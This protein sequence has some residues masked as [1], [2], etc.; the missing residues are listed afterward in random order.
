[1]PDIDLKLLYRFGFICHRKGEEPL[2]DEVWQAISKDWLRHPYGNFVVWLHP[3]TTLSVCG[4]NDRRA[5]VIGDAIGVGAREGRPLAQGAAAVSNGELPDVLYDYTGRF[6]LFILEGDDAL[7]FNDPIGSRSVF[8]TVTDPVAVAS[9]AAL[10][11][12]AQSR[13][14][15]EDMAAFVVSEPFRKRKPAYLP[16]DDTIHQDTY[17]LIANN[18]F[19]VGQRRSIRYWPSLR[20]VKY[21]FDELLA[22]FDNYFRSLSGFLQ[23]KNTIV[24]ITGGIDSRT[25]IAGLRYY[26]SVPQGVTW[27]RYVFNEPERAVIELVRN[28]TKMSHR[29]ID[30]NEYS[31]NKV[32]VSAQE[33]AGGFRRRSLVVA[34]M[35]DAYSAV[36][37]PVYVRGYGGEILRAPKYRIRNTMNSM[38]IDDM[39]KAY[40]MGTRKQHLGDKTYLRAI[41]ACYE[42][43]ASRVT[44]ADCE[45]LDFNPNDIFYWENRI[46]TWGTHMMNEMDPAMYSM[47]GLNSRRLFEMAF[48]LP[49]EIRFP[50]GHPKELLRRVIGHYD[51]ELARVPHI[52]GNWGKQSKQNGKT[53]SA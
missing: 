34:A 47:T 18:F 1:M 37:A 41:E 14:V 19:D 6:A 9:H 49:D 36:E 12:R 24:S 3:E 38:S 23:A 13:S 50:Q 20:R 8:Y 40:V 33:N 21:G 11:A 26:N 7:I 46:G 10:L 16:G 39:V 22:E 25:I 43:Y 32:T 2:G 30:E 31:A 15:R 53:E 27:L 44:P 29:Y 45:G 51:P 52:D 28:A 4:D 35:R 48:G 42:G 5:L 17:Q